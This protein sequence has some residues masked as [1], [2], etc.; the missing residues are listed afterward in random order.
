MGG[1]GAAGEGYWAGRARWCTVGLVVW[2]WGLL[3]NAWHDDE[4][5]EI[6]REVARRRGRE[7]AAAEAMAR[8]NGST[9]G[10]KAGG[11]GKEGAVGR[12]GVDK[13]YMLPK[14][15]L[16]QLVLYPHYLCE[17]VEWAGFWMVAGSGCAPAR[18]FLCN[19]VATMVPRAVQGWRWYV[20]VFGKEKVGGRKAVVPWLI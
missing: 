4:L 8:G 6:R 11:K 18:V 13:V 15:G 16:F 17:W 2:G 14:N 20:R 9:G 3:A 10:D 5:R 7:A 1:Y 12:K 19:E